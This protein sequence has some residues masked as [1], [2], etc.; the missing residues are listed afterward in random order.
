MAGAE[1]RVGLRISARY[2]T[3]KVGFDT[4]WYTGS[5]LAVNSDGSC[6][7]AYDDGEMERGILPEHVKVAT[8]SF[9]SLKSTPIYGGNGADGKRELSED[10]K[11]AR[12]SR[13]KGV[14]KNKRAGKAPAK[15][16]EIPSEGGS[17][18]CG[19]SSSMDGGSSCHE[20]AAAAAA[21]ATVAVAAAALAQPSVASVAAT[22]VAVAVSAA[23]AALT[24]APIAAAVPEPD[25]LERLRRRLRRR[26][27]AV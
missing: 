14:G 13:G 12:A 10:A 17:G 15:R 4:A 5:V 26:V 9:C 20:A 2:Q 16:C 18:G 11:L 25:H 1:L 22:A 27:G 6:D 23:D 19:G 3:N 21:A 7:I 24:S 8:H